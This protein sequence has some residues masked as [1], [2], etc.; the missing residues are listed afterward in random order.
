MTTKKLIVIEGSDGSGKKTQSDLLT[1]SLGRYTK[2]TKFSFPDYNGPF[3]KEIKRYLNGEFGNLSEFDIALNQYTG[4]AD[5]KEDW[6]RND[7]DKIAMALLNGALIHVRL[8]SVLYAADRAINLPKLKE[9]LAL[10][11]VVC[12]RYDISNWAHQ[13]A[14]LEGEKRENLIVWLK[15]L[16]REQ[17]GLPVPDLVVYLNLPPEKA[18]EA[19]KKE[20]RKLD[21][22]EQDLDYLVKVNDLYLE[23]AQKENWPI[24]ECLKRDGIRK[25]AGEVSDEIWEIVK[26]IAQLA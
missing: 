1:T 11:V 10:G 9:A 20:G 14:K 12:D 22:H 18:H 23:I 7:A 16:E 6:L 24:I 21:M 2:T 5:W 19:M 17:I 26:P 3:G 15:R 13:G 8:A 4:T 25:T